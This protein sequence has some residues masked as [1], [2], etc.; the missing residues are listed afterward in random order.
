MIVVEVEEEI[1]DIIRVAAE[2]EISAVRRETGKRVMN[3]NV[4]LAIN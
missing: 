3:G 2:E 1:A 4:I